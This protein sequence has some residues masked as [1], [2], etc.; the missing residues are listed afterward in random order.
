MK[1]FKLMCS[2]HGHTSDVKSLCTTKEN[3]GFASASRDLTAKLWKCIENRSYCEEQTVNEHT[4]FVNSVAV[5]YSIANYPNGLIVTGSND[6]TIA[7]NDAQSRQL[8]CK[9]KEHEGA[10]KFIFSFFVFI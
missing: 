10:G 7:I 5:I 2:L 1:P 6:Q 8:L 3:G 4:K 9:L